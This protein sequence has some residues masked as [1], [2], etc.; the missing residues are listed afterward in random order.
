MNI[1]RFITISA[2]ICSALYA[3]GRPAHVGSR[4]YTQPDGTQI[5]LRLIGNEHASITVTADEHALP[6]VREGETYYYATLSSSGI[7]ASTGIKAV[8]YQQLSADQRTIL[9][10]QS[11]DDMLR[12]MAT[13][14]FNDSH[15]G[16]LTDNVTVPCTGNVKCLAV[17]VNYTDIKFTTPNVA[18][19]Y[20][21]I[22]NA[23]DVSA[24]SSSA[25]GSVSSYFRKQSYGA[26]NPEFD[27]YGPITLAHDRAYYGTNNYYGSDQAAHEMA[28]E[29]AAQL[30]AAGVDLAQYDNDGNGEVDNILVIYAGETAALPGNPT[31]CVWPHSWNISYGGISEADRTFGNIKVDHYI[32]ANELQG[33]RADGIGTVVHEF[34]HALGLPDLYST[35]TSNMHY[36]TPCWWSVMDVGCDLGDGWTPPLYSTYERYALG[37]ADPLEMSEKKYYLLTSMAQDGRSLMVSNPDNE[38]EKYFFEYRTLTGWDANLPASGVLIWRLR[39]E[40]PLFTDNAPNNDPSRML[41]DLI[42]AKRTTPV[43]ADNVADFSS[44]FSDPWPQTGATSFTSTTSPA[45]LTDEGK[46]FYHAD[47]TENRILNI[48]TGISGKA[49]LGAYAT[50]NRPANHFDV[51]THQLYDAIHSVAADNA[52]ASFS[53]SGLDLTITA[54]SA[55]E[56]VVCTPSGA[57]VAI[58]KLIPGQTSTVTL[59]ASGL[60]ILRAGTT[61]AK[62]LAR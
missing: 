62:I 40:E 5:S 35:D 52:D 8:P 39:Y 55:S 21:A 2:I 46:P 37:W 18:E 10:A 54:P 48:S 61:A 45:F 14:S 51:G 4:T 29:A 44:F 28:L 22:L 33:G 17:L 30:Y 13:N 42:E 38:N 47:G 58:R 49:G 57:V 15:I 32:C 19:Y 56:A 50:A 53:L 11:S 25:V 31:E 59:P 27:V 60:Y 12:S 23:D 7:L 16:T 24:Y 26:F 3:S 6:L 34:S 20:K 43:T 1:T 9:S 41:L 36:N